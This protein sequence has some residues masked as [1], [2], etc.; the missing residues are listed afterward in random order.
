MNNE[1]GRK[2]NQSE[3]KKIVRMILS[4]KE[5]NF[6]NKKDI[7][8]S[9]A[10]VSSREMKRINRLYRKKDKTTDVLSFYEYKSIDDLKKEKNTLVFLGEIILC[11]NDIR[12]Y[13]QKEKKLFF[14]E[15]VKVIA[16]GVLHLLGMKHGKRMF[17]IQDK[18]KL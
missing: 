5:F 16:H 13:V 10:A 2:I 12:N 9:F 6:L 17:E 18:I 15:I 7:S 8:L 14:G 3:L 4:E 11:Y 1:M